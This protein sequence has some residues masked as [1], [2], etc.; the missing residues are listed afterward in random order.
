MLKI[1]LGDLVYDTFSTNYVVPLNIAFIA[2]YVKEKY[3]SDVDIVIFKYP[4]ELEKAI[5]FAPPDILG[6][7]NYS[8]NERLNNVFFKMA[9]RLNPNVITVMGG[10]NIRT[11]ND[12]IEKFLSANKLLD[13]YILFEGE[14]PFGSLVEIVLG[15]SK[16][17]KPPLG[18]ASLVEGH[19]QFKLLDFKKKPKQIDLPSPYLTGILDRFL[20]NPNIIPLFETNRGCPFG[21]TYCTWGISALSKVRTRSLGVVLE[22]LDY[23][24]HKSAKQV[25]W[26]F[27]DA[28][29]GIL[30]RDVEIAQKIRQIMDKK[31]YPINVTLWHSKNTSERNIEIAKI[32]KDNDASI[33]IQSTDPEVLKN[34]GRGSIKLSQ[35]K[36]QIDYFKDNFLEVD[37]DILI[38][39]PCETAESHMN[40]L[41]TSF[42]LGFGS[43]NPTNIRMLPGSQYES[44]LDREKYGIETAFR[45]IFGAY[46]V[47]DGQRVFEIEESVRATK[48]MTES[49]LESFKIVHWLIFFSYN[50]GIFKAPLRF[51]QQHGAN[52]AVILH[53][54]YS[55]KP[56]SLVDIFKKMEKESMDEWFNTE[57]EISLYYEQQNHF[58]ELVNNFAKLNFLW[59][60]R[61]YQNVN[62]ISTLLSELLRIINDAIKIESQEPI[63]NWDDLLIIVDKLICKDLLQKEFVSRIKITGETLSYALNDPNLL[64]EEFVEAEIYRT[65]ED[66]AF[67][68]YHLNPDGKRD[69]SIQNLTRFIE[70]GGM[71]MLTNR[72]RVVDK[73]K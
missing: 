23:V 11:D 19:L 46:G 51:A 71:K 22:E 65:K 63:G 31:G 15:G 39:L 38:G 64:K 17:S 68:N 37:T 67:C 5:K 34:C 66:V 50:T 14:E 60:A 32:I 26:I 8:W 18:C 36:R 43:I 2:A 33:A 30:K 20:L 61:V 48:D 13:Y 25:N 49:E 58:D 9:K 21:C 29:F 28:N 70:I 3:T 42:N 45:P 44:E 69:F 6:L 62:I 52:P 73:E 1:Y 4:Q 54:L 53:Q 27:C 35:L 12:G 7:S 24:A 55:C 57:E 10:P 47:Y 56:Y 59:I 72:I 40:T 41:I 16:L